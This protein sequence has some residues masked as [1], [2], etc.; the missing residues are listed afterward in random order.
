VKKYLANSLDIKKLRYED[1]KGEKKNFSISQF[2]NFLEFIAYKIQVAYMRPKR[3]REIVKLHRVRFHPQDCR[4]WILKKYKEK[5][6][7][8]SI[9]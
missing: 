9:M 2:L 8:Y 7:D 3:T 6:K 1:I 5:L 4:K